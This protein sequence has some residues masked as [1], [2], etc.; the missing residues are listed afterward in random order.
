MVTN[1][2]WQ[3]ARETGVLA[4][5]PLSVVLSVAPAYDTQERYRGLTDA[6]AVSILADMRR[7][8]V[9][10]VSRDHFAQFIPLEI[11]FGHREDALLSK[12]RV[13]L[14]QLPKEP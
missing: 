8:G 13:A 10:A 7:D 9:D 12:Y 1:I 2:A 6:M 11:D 5:I 4:D 3:A 14:A